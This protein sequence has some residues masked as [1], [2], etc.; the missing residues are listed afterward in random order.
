MR[1]FNLFFIICLLASPA[2]AIVLGQVD[3]FDSGSQGWLSHSSAA[4]M[5][6][7]GPGGASDPFLQVTSDLSAELDVYGGSSW[8]GGVNYLGAGVSAIGAHV[9]NLG[10]SLLELR[11]LIGTGASNSHYT[12]IQAV[13]LPADG[14][15]HYVL[16][17]LTTSD[18]A[19]VGSGLQG[20]LEATLTA[21]KSLKIRHQS[22]A[23][24]GP[25]SR[26]LIAGSFGIDNITAAPEPC[27]LV[28][29]LLASVNLW[30]R[31][32]PQI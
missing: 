3:T 9:R 11:L 23:P 29:I 2:K 16:F 31:R 4:V 18:L 7:G 19:W 20:D 32:W 12:S 14:Q 10:T 6:G 22:G 28:G 27:T 30:R 17:G 1:L 21:V 8:S 13:P 15:W 24:L 25:Q 5:P 26:T